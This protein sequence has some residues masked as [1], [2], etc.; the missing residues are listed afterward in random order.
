MTA[1]FV[2]LFCGLLKNRD[3]SK[4]DKARLF[5]PREGRL[6]VPNTNSLHGRPMICVLDHE[7]ATMLE[8]SVWSEGIGFRMHEDT[9][10]FLRFEELEQILSVMTRP[11]RSV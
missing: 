10:T 2:Q 1:R 3:G 5:L 8:I 7:S 11:E 4:K 6:S 9:E